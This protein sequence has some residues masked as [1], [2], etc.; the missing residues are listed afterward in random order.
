MQNIL[1]IVLKFDVID[2]LEFVLF[3]WL[4]VNIVLQVLWF[5]KSKE[6]S[7]FETL[8]VAQSFGILVLYFWV[9]LLR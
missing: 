3:L 9:W 4:V 5:A 8:T 2:I 1:T 7:K 6:N